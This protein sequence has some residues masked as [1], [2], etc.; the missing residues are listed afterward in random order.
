M[1][2]HQESDE[3]LINLDVVGMDQHIFVNKVQFYYFS[4]I[5]RLKQ[6]EFFFKGSRSAASSPSRRFA[7]QGMV[8]LDEIESLEDLSQLSAKQCKDLLAVNRVN[9]HGILEK[10]ELVRIAQRLWTQEQK[11]DR[12]SVV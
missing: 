7:N 10:E 8:R 12:K 5:W 9:H 2:T 1:S 11:A 3:S 4:N 6:A